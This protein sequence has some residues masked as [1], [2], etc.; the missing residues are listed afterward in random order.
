LDGTAIKE[1]LN[2]AL[3]KASAALSSEAKA[4]IQRL[5]DYFSIAMGPH[6]KYRQY[7]EIIERLTLAIDRKRT[8]EMRYFSASRNVTGRRAVDPY[9]IW[10]AAGALYLIGYCHKRSDVRMFAV[11]RI[12]SL[13]ITNRPCQMPLGFDI[14]AYVQDALVVMRGKPIE[15]ELVFDAGV[16]AWVKDREW[17][18]SQK[19]MPLRGGRLQMQ[20]S[21]S[22][23]PE[24]VGWILSFGAGVRVASPESLRLRILD[25]AKKICEKMT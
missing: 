16:A 12:R 1:S 10:Y 14:E 20:L 11:E 7:K 17:H 24:L 3:N 19:L 9:R 5:R 2:S 6:K 22:D 21:V 23:T 15:V 13:A 25:E 8:V 18:P 4:Y